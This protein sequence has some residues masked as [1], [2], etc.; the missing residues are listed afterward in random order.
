MESALRVMFT[1]NGNRE[2][3]L[4]C[5]CFAQKWIRPTAFAKTLVDSLDDIQQSTTWWTPLSRCYFSYL[6]FRHVQSLSF[7]G[8]SLFFRLKERQI[9]FGRIDLV[10]ANCCGANWPLGE[11]TWYHLY[12]VSKFSLCSSF[13][14]H[15]FFIFYFEKFSTW[16]WCLLFAV[17]LTLN[18]SKLYHYNVRYWLTC[19]SLT[20]ALM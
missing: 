14:V 11:T 16:N 7:H 18:L 4:N 5:S 6:W 1:A 12:Q 9:C 2:F 17:D 3:V 8:Y 13:T 20:L 10:W 19:M 15:Y